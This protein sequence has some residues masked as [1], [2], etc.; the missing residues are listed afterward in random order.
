MNKL[1]LVLSLILMG[2]L[3][4]PLSKCEYQAMTED[5]G[6]AEPEVTIRYAVPNESGF[7]KYLWIIPF[8]L[9]IACSSFTYKRKPTVLNELAHALVP[10]PALVVVWLHY[11][12]GSLLVGAYLAIGCS[13]ILLLIAIVRFYRAITKRL[14]A[15]TPK[16]GAP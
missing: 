12:I 16:I 1:R 7:V 13:L 9:P 5:G 8:V 15:G 3:V 11:Q 6:L 4:L 14:N 2:A 10:V